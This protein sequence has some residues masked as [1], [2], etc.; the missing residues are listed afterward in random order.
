MEDNLFQEW[1]FE[2]TSCNEITKNNLYNLDLE[3]FF[4]K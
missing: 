2:N 3:C 1:V 4:P